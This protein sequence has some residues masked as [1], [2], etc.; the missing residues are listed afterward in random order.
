M[1]EYVG[2]EHR[3]QRRFISRSGLW[4]SGKTKGADVKIGVGD[5]VWEI[6]QH[7]PRCAEPINACEASIAGV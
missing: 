7:S 2:R 5:R 6:G 4:F 1:S 3:T